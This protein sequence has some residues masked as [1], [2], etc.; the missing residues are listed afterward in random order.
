MSKPARLFYFPALIAILHLSAMAV[1]TTGGKGAGPEKG[2]II[3]SIRIAPKS[4]NPDGRPVVVVT[5]SF[6]GERAPTYRRN[7]SFLSSFAGF[8]GLADRISNIKLQD[9]KGMD[10]QFKELVRGEYIADHEIKSWSYTIDLTVPTDVRA[11]AHV[12][13]LSDDVGILMPNDLL[14]RSGDDSEPA[15]LSVKVPVGWSVVSPKALE[16]S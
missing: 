11:A 4:E 2:L 1:S 14:P 7:F 3:A 5:G 12:S 10:L 16:P 13:W 8:R 9:S 15:W 6:L